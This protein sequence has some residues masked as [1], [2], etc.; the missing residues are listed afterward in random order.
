MAGKSWSEVDV[1]RM[2]RLYT[3]GMSL[4]SVA[5]RL[6]RDERSVACKLSNLRKTGREIPYQSAHG[7]KKVT[8]RRMNASSVPP[9]VPVV[10]QE[11]VPSVSPVL[12][13]VFSPA[14]PK[15][16]AFLALASVGWGVRDL[17]LAFDCP[18]AAV[19]VLFPAAAV[20]EERGRAS[21]RR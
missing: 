20:A 12:P 15:G 14:D 5:R 6:S 4:A 17:A 19:K 9:G 7:G 1:E 11:P 2:I 10:P 8:G 13:G 16:A 18:E 21:N 3:G